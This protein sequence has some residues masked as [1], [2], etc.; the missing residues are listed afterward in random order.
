MTKPSSS[1]LFFIV[2]GS[3]EKTEKSANEYNKKLSLFN[4]TEQGKKHDIDVSL[5]VDQS[6]RNSFVLHEGSSPQAL[7]LP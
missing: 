4:F 1:S 6:V 7:V 3:R 5:S 2:R